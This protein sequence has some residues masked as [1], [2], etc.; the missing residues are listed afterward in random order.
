MATAQARRLERMLS[1]WRA[2]RRWREEGI[3]LL[4]SLHCHYCVGCLLFVG[5]RQR[6][7]NSQLCSLDLHLSLPLKLK[8]TSFPCLA[9]VCCNE[10]PHMGPATTAADGTGQLLK[11]VVVR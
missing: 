6:A 4:S 9:I 3:P 7:P 2:G 5:K 1:V 10:L 8:V 11:K